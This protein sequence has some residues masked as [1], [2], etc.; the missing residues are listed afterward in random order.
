MSGSARAPRTSEGLRWLLLG[1]ILALISSA[2]TLTLS[3]ATVPLTYSYVFHVFVL[4]LAG[5]SLLT[6]AFAVGV[7]GMFGVWEGRHETGASHAQA[8]R[9]ASQAAWV[10]LGCVGVATVLGLVL[11]FVPLGLQAGELSRDSLPYLVV[12]DLR[13]SALFLATP[14]LGL[15]LFWI[16]RDLGTR[17]TNVLAGAALSLG[18]LA[19]FGSILQTDLGVVPG[20]LLSM[21]SVGLWVI[22]YAAALVRL[23]GGTA[24]PSAGSA[25]A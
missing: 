24:A 11:G 22:V 21:A 1:L 6:A 25:A 7:P 2:V 10:V 20:V 12:H 3:W 5:V 18:V 15:F 8:V 16:A 13:S 9:R 23:K 14:A 17:E 19:A 4:P